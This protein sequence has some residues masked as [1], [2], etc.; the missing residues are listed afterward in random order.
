MT[1]NDRATTLIRALPYI[2]EY[3]KKTVVIK[4]GGNAMISESLK[5]AVIRD[6]VMLWLI[7]V[8]VVLIHGGGP[9]ITEMLSKV[10]KE[11][12]FINGLRYTDS[13][14]MDIVQMVLCGKLNKDLVSF[15]GSEGGRAVGLCGL[16]G[17][18]LKAEKVSKAGIDYGYV[19]EISEVDVSIINDVI[20]K[21]MIP[22]ISTVAKGEHNQSMNIN[23]DLAASKIAIALNAE[24][25]ILLTDVKGIMKDYRDDDSLISVV[26]LSEIEELKSSGIISGG[27]IPKV[28]CCFEAVENNVSRAHI[29]D[30]RVPHSILIEMLSDEGVGTMIIKD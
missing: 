7:G 4:Y 27:M 15:I 28:D 17:N 21:G 16:D 10:G 12:K 24:K 25:L 22:V 5:E 13:E 19:G 6:I 14:T 1:V 2:K 9:E 18:M 29:I 11:S 3:H 20:E 23:A 30:G 8:N 26:R